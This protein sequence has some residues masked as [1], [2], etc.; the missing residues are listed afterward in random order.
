MSQMQSLNSFESCRHDPCRVTLPIAAWLEFPGVF[1]NTAAGA[2]SD[3]VLAK[4]TLNPIAAM[5]SMP[6]QRNDDKRLGASDDGKKLLLN[7]QP[8]IPLELHSAWSLRSRTVVPLIDQNGKAPSGAL[9]APGFVDITQSLF[10]S[11]QSP[12]SGGWIRGAGPV[13]LHP[14]ASDKHL[15]SEKWGFRLTA[16]V[17]RQ[18]NGW[19]D[20]VLGNRLWPVAG[21]DARTDISSTFLQPFLSCTTKTHTTF[22]INTESSCD[23]KNSAWTRPIILMATQMLRIRGQ[24]LALQAGARYWANSPQGGPEG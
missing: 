22:S 20:G 15:G 6:I 4:K 24:P 16:V 9:D 8:V 11:P 1:M 17:L 3:E 12:A 14:T 5:T 10:A 21:N 7:A 23:G 18:R 19:T 2:E 13:C